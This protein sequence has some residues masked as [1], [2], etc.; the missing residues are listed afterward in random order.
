MIGQEQ[1]QQEDKSTFKELG[2]GDTP[3]PGSAGAREP[4]SPT[5]QCSISLL[6]VLNICRRQGQGGRE[7]GRKGIEEGR[8]EKWKNEAEKKG[9]WRK[10]EDGK[11]EGEEMGGRG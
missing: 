3:Q 1:R 8:K 5:Q 9:G 10:N 4:H 7:G 11:M 6:L 2:K